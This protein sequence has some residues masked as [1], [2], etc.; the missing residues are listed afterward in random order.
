MGGLY[1]LLIAINNDAYMKHWCN[2]SEGEGDEV[3]R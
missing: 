3:L 1:Q 2:D